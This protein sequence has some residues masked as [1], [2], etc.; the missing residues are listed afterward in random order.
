MQQII[1]NVSIRTNNVQPMNTNLLVYVSRTVNDGIV[2][3]DVNQP[4]VDGV[5]VTFLNQ[6]GMT[7]TF[8]AGGSIGFTML[9]NSQPTT[10]DIPD[11]CKRVFIIQ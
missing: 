5:F 6:S 4:Y 10:F 7:K 11:L 9:D 1:D 2:V 8:S 3:S